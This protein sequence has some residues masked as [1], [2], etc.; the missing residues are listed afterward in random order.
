MNAG[1]AF[2][3]APSLLAADLAE[4]G[5]AADLC[6]EGGA[7][8]IHFDV[9][10]GHF[11]PNLSFGIPVLKALSRR[12]TLPIDVH[13]MVEDPGRLLDAYLDAGAA[14]VSFHWE[15]GGHVDRMLSAIRARGARAG[16]ALNPATPVELLADVLGR[17]DFVLLMSVNPGFGGQAFLPYTLDKARRLR[18]LIVERRLDVAIEMDGGLGADNLQAAVAA[19]VEIAV[20]GSSVFGEPDPVAAMQRLRLLAR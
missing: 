18:K 12:T 7:D 20:A 10:D 1:R 3:L 19:G 4:I 17:L 16:I 6:R 2:Q 15:A 14:W 9:M 8:L 5:K 13:L 11:V